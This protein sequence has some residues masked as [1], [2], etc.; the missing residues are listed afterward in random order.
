M[1]EKVTFEQDMK[2]LEEIVK[3]LEQGDIPL[4][5]AVEKFKQGIDLSKKLQN[6]LL[7]AE[8][9]LTKVIDDNGD[10]QLFERENED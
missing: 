7:Q 3:K 2:N 6:T 4:E 10:E 8:E 1:A 9:T 5:E